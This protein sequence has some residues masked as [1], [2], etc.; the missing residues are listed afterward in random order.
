MGNH[1][2]K[3]NMESQAKIKINEEKKEE[4]K[5]KRSENWNEEDKVSFFKV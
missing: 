2:F 4:S 3:N 1:Q 5:R